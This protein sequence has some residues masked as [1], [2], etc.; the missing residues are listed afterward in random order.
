M[1]NKFFQ[2]IQYVM[3]DTGIGIFIDRNSGGRMRN[4]SN[5]QAIGYPALGDCFADLAGYINEFVSLMRFD[6]NRLHN[7]FTPAK[8]W[9]KPKIGFGN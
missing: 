6:S 5:H 4:K 9:C 1:G 3:D 2:A 7:L 8:V